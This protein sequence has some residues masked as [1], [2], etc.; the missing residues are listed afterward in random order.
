MKVRG[1]GKKEEIT[2]KCKRKI[3]F[4]RKGRRDL[5]K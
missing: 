5:E 3:V 1:G 2:R 4:G